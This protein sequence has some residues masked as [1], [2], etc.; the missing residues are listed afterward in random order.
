MRL[1]KLF[2]CMLYIFSCEATE[3]LYHKLFR[4]KAPYSNKYAEQIVKTQNIND[5]KAFCD[6]TRIKSDNWSHFYILTATQGTPDLLE[7][8]CS[9]HKLDSKLI[10]NVL[11]YLIQK[12]SENDVLLLGIFLNHHN[13]AIVPTLHEL[14]IKHD[15]IS[16]F[17]VFQQILGL[18]QKSLITEDLI[19][20]FVAS[21]NN[22]KMPYTTHLLNQPWIMTQEFID[23]AAIYAIDA[24]TPHYFS[25]LTRTGMLSEDAI[26]TIY[27]LHTPNNLLQQECLKTIQ[28]QI[29]TIRSKYRKSYKTPIFN[30]IPSSQ[31]ITKHNDLLFY[32]NSMYRIKIHLA[33]SPFLP[34]YLVTFDEDEQC[35]SIL[36]NYLYVER[37]MRGISKSSFYRAKA[38]T[39]ELEKEAYNNSYAMFNDKSY[40]IN[41]YIEL[42]P[43]NDSS[44]YNQHTVWELTADNSQFRRL[45]TAD[46]F[47]A[48]SAAATTLESSESDQ[49][50]PLLIIP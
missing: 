12:S 29:A 45:F 11:S 6:S 21:I 33:A 9:Y 5:F 14:I 23:Q 19:S 16:K 43:E 39:P 41:L 48:A 30:K 42:A 15:R 7:F 38:L 10:G 18:F 25:M 35:S 27:T 13:N 20:L 49:H 28:D 36:T 8:L 24:C 2:I 50:E 4:Y 17:P 44:V 1:L 34:P 32:Q 26:C 47:A 40:P 22:R 37:P 3:I 46:N 31:F